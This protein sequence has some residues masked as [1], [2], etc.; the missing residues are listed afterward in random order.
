V[1]SDYSRSLLLA[2]QATGRDASELERALSAGMVTVSIDPGMPAALLTA[3][4]LLTTLRRGPGHL[5][6]ERSAVPN[7]WIEDLETAVA[8]VDPEQPLTI[9]GSTT[10]QGVRLH[11]GTGHPHAIRVVPDGYGAHVAGD[12]TVVMTPTR[13]ANPLGA[14]FAA[15]LGAAE[16]FK[17]TAQ[18]L[19]TRRVLHRH[20]RFCP[21]ML[22]SD[23]TAA[24]NLP[25]PP[26]CDLTQ[27]GIGAI[28]TGT[29]LLL[30]ALRAE[31]RLV[32]VDYQRFGPE[33]RGT[34][35][36]GGAAEVA[37]APW[38]ADMARQALP[39]FDVTPFRRPVSEL[40]AAIDGGEVP[41][42]PVVLT[43]LDTAA[44]RRDAQRLWPDRL[45]DAGT[46][47]T[48]LGIHD[49]EHGSG[50][51]LTCLFP[52]DRSGPSAAERLAALTGLSLERAMRA[53]DP[54]A[55]G[56]LVQLTAEQ[57]QM[58]SPHL[59]KPVCGLAQAVGL[60]GLGADG[61]QPSIPFVSLQAACLA[62]GRLIA[63]QLNLCPPGNLVQYDGLIG[64]QAATNE[65][66]RRRPDC[67][68]ATR[69]TTIEQVRNKRRI[70]TAGPVK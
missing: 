43:A 5:I 18:V 19:H 70:E 51:C 38:K 37:A 13:A 57:Q 64:P 32:A 58:L 33:N 22:S 10:A 55:E 31:G 60:T 9:T 40:P 53:D 67:V 48:M 45:I 24:P 62:V 29:I 1:P 2:Q 68:C 65:E 14:I 16:A 25:F 30:Q 54:L 46:G 63:S 35:S 15:A 69:A 21:V 3:R 42:L 61:Y 56:D 12:P 6:L 34:Y 26:V 66:M 4:T 59:G 8:A 49:H 50:P 52:P 11:I 20:L 47:D 28:G 44:A 7:S 27:V 36:L 41:W 23:L 39:R 17:W